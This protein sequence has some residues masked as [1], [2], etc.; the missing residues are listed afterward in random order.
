M[1]AMLYCLVEVESLPTILIN[2]SFKLPT[3]CNCDCDRGY[4][5]KSHKDFLNEKNN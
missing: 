3:D 4:A 5:F 1:T 2:S